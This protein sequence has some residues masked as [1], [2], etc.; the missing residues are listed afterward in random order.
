MFVILSPSKRRA[1]K[2]LSQTLAI[3]VVAKNVDFVSCT[4]LVSRREWSLLR[5]VAVFVM[6]PPS[7]PHITPYESF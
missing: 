2:Y 6:L 1:R 7:L 4:G 3:I 5:A